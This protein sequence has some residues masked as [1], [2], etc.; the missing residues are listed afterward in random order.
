[1][2]EII[3]YLQSWLIVAAIL[4]CLT[5]LGFYFDASIQKAEGKEPKMPGWPKRINLA[6]AVLIFAILP[7]L[8]IVGSIA[9]LIWMLCKIG[10][11]TLWEKNIRSQ[12]QQPGNNPGFLVPHNILQLVIQNILQ[13]KGAT[14][15]GFDSE[16]RQTDLTGRLQR[17]ILCRRVPGTPEQ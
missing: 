2:D 6:G 5:C 7:V 1:M 14:F 17:R 12:A 3:Y 15:T 11:I 13:E 4:T 10:D 16:D 9:G 8:V